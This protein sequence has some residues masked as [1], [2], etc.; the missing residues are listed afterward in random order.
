MFSPIQI[1]KRLS[2]ASGFLDLSMPVEAV[3]EL[4][5]LLEEPQLQT[6]RPLRRLHGEALIE[7]RQFGEAREIYIGILGERPEDVDA[8]IKKAWCE[9]RMGRLPAAI[10]TMERAVRLHPREAVLQYNLACYHALAVDKPRCLSR[11]GVA[12]RL[13][14]SIAGM[15]DSESDFD[16]FRQDADFNSLIAMA[17]EK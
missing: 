7:L 14:R 5:P 10:R 16:N 13:D 17:T 2:A 3:A 9:K 4:K 11:L 12:I 8:A 6:L 15:I 1:S